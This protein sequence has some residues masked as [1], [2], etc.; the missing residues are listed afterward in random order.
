MGACGLQHEDLSDV[1]SRRNRS[2]ILAVFWGSLSSVCVGVTQ[3][4]TALKRGIDEGTS[5]HTSPCCAYKFCAELNLTFFGKWSPHVSR[6]FVMT[7]ASLVS[8]LPVRFTALVAPGFLSAE[9]N[10][11]AKNAHGAGRKCQPKAAKQQSL[12][13]R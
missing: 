13:M 1:I 2:A 11:V 7:L 6:M 5:L 12:L 4:H 8:V 3:T 9:G 10:S